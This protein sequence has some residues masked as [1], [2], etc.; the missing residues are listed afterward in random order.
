MRSG[1][2]LATLA[3]LSWSA[4]AVPQVR[5]TAPA[6]GGKGPDASVRKLSPAQ[7]TAAYKDYML[8][9]AGCHRFDGGGAARRGVP[10]F[11]GSIGLLADTPAG[12]D[13]MVRVPGAAQSQLSDAELANVLNWAVLTYGPAVPDFQAFTAAEVGAARPHRFN[14]VARVRREL[15]GQ[16]ARKGRVLAPYTYGMNPAQ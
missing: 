7:S 8:Q 15:A 2:A 9:C 11:R 4:A 10:S 3:L 1:I 6:G 5:G 14:D 12:R 16:L 13:Y